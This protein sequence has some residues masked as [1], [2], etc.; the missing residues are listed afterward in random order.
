[1]AQSVLSNIRQPKTY[2]KIK[3]LLLGSAA[4]LSFAA[5][6]QDRIHL[7]NGDVIDGKVS[8]VGTRDISYKKA[9]NPD[10]PSYRLGKGEISRIEYENGSEDVFGMHG[11]VREGK[12][13]A[14]KVKYGKNILAIA[15]LQISDG[16]GVGFSYE[17][18]L[19]KKGI[20]SF[21]MPLMVGFNNNSDVMPF[22][23]S[24]YNYNEYTSYTGM[25]GI[26]IY[27]TG[28]KGKVKY[29]VGPAIAARY[30]QTD[31][32][33]VFMGYDVYG[34]P[35]YTTGK[36][37]NFALG[38]VINN[39]LN[40]QPTAHLYL[41]LEIGLGMSYIN[42]TNGRNNGNEDFLGQFAFKL[43]YRF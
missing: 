35:I 13:D 16:I 20:V 18:V 29:A 31:A 5:S 4:L 9:D 32:Y 27:P 17:R 37:D 38:V 40:I 25:V 36:Q 7:R 6:A 42:Q 14:P 39:S 33:N 15:P 12:P 22:S 1:M 34:Y 3:S 30:A 24:Y 19:D 2:M 23:S 8:E 28:S 11:R 26:K 43:G 10:G 41:G 21:Y